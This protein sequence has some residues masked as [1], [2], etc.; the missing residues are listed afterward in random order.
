MQFDGSHQRTRQ[1]PVLHQLHADLHVAHTQKLRFNIRQ[2]EAH[3]VDFFQHFQ[4]IVGNRAQHRETA[5]VHQQARQKVIAVNRCRR[6]LT[7]N[8]ARRRLNHRLFPERPVVGR[9]R[10]RRDRFLDQTETQHQGRHNVFPQQGDGPLQRSDF[11]LESKKR[12][13]CRLE[14]LSS[15]RRV[16]LDRLDNVPNFGFRVARQ[17]QQFHGDRRQRRKLCGCPDV[18]GVNHGCRRLVW[19]AQSPS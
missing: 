14:D 19:C 13:V 16:R 18:A 1:V 7:Q 10:S 3:F 9:K 8:V 6:E 5:D 17:F 12:G 11:R 4:I 15:Q 2:R